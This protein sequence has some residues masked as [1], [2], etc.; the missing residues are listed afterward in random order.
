MEV[1]SANRIATPSSRWLFWIR[2]AA[3][4]A[5]TALL[6]LVFR[7]L[8][9]AA[10]VEGLRTM[11]RGWF[12]AAVVVYGGLFLPAAARWHLVLRLNQ[13]TV[14]PWTTLRACL[15]GH[16]FYVLLFGA[17]GG[18]AARSALY[19]HWYRQPLAR[20]LATAPLDRLLGLLGLLLFGLVALVGAWATE[21]LGLAGAMVWEWQATLLV[22]LVILCFASWW[23]IGRSAPGSFLRRFGDNLKI[24]GKQLACSPG[25]AIAGVVCGLLVQVALSASLG[26]NLE[27]VSH[28]ALPWGEMVWVF[29]VIALLGSL[30]VTVAGLGAREGAALMLLSR[31]GISGATAVA[32]ALLTFAASLFWAFIAAILL[33][34]EMRKH[35]SWGRHSVVTPSRE[36]A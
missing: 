33:W 35:G 26:L 13:A 11:N 22:S 16:F 10:L 7:R 15:V 9:L 21:G 31:F 4:I 6:Y 27:A 23:V 1:D 30:P 36:G 24:S 29:P 19:A 14:C 17:V 18:D 20:V 5:T 2:V 28:S 25:T 8:R 34:L 12:V 3:V 32:A